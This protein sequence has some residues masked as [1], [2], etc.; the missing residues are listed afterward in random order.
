MACEA[1]ESEISCRGAELTVAQAVPDSRPLAYT[2]LSELL[3]LVELEHRHRM[4]KIEVELL[5]LC[6]EV[7]LPKYTDK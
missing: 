2:S 1:C 7:V 3:T 6:T 5:K 4:L